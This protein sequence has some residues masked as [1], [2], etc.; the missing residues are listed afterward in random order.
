MSTRQQ[1]LVGVLSKTADESADA[2]HEIS[3]LIAA[4]ALL[5][6]QASD[7]SDVNAGQ[8][9]SAV[10]DLAAAADRA[11]EQTGPRTERSRRLLFDASRGLR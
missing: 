1:S 5:A 10:A 11:L 3:A 2:E 6:R 4:C 8:F 7:K 9:G